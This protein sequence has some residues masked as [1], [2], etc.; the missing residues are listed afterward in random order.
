M[1]FSKKKISF[2]HLIL[3]GFCAFLG[4]KSI[5]F[6]FYTYIISS[7]FVFY[8]VPQ[9]KLEC[10][11]AVG[12]LILSIILLS[13]F[14]IR[15]KEILHPTYYRFLTQEDIS[16]IRSLNSRRLFN[17]YDYGGELIYY[18]IPVFI[19]GRA[20][21]YSSYNYLDYLHIS[22]LQGDFVSLLDS[23]SFDYFLVDKNYPIYTYL[24]YDNHYELIYSNKNVRIFQTKESL[25]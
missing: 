20:D 25:S 23:Y 18:D 10:G 12:V 9:W 15:S 4:L 6:W 5:R 21:L 7:Y 11:T 19:D 24:R 22:M 1:L 14:F 16:M 8:Y 2:I 3:F 17:M 13:F